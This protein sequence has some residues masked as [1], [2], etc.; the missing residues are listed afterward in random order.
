MGKYMLE[1]IEFD[2]FESKDERFR[3]ESLLRVSFGRI[4]GKS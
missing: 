1:P 2:N 3:L 4:G